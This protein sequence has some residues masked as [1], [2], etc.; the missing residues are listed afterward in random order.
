MNSQIVRKHPGGVVAWIKWIKWWLIVVLLASA[1]ILP[2]SFFLQLFDNPVVDVV[3]VKNKIS[4]SETSNYVINGSNTGELEL[5]NYNFLNSIIFNTV[6][7]TSLFP[8]LFSFLIA[9]QLF[10]I[11]KKLEIHRAFYQEISKRIQYIGIILITISITTLLRVYYMDNI[12]SKLTQHTF[13]VNYKLYNGDIN[14]FKVGILVLII[15][16]IYKRGCSL[17]QEQ[18]LTI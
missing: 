5:L 15:A 14:S 3:Q 1:I 4:L 11:F 10:L 9:L 6:G 18:D 16:A 7:P 17:Q 8:A 13:K 12:V 2:L